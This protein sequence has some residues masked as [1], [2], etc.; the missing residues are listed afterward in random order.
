MSGLERLAHGLGRIVAPNPS[1]MTGPG[2][3][4][5]LL[6]D[7]E[8]AVIDPGPD[9][10]AHLS[11]ILSAAGRARI[12]HIL[13]THAH[14]DHSGLARRLSEATGAPILAFG[15]ARAGRS[16][17]MRRLDLPE[18]GAGIDTVFAPD[19]RLRD[20]DGVHGA[21]W[22][23]GAFWTPGHFGNHL[24]FG[25]RDTVFTGD[26]IMGWSSS[27]ISP[28]DG[29]LRDYL[30]SCARVRRMAPRRLFPGHG[31]TIDAPKARIDDLIRRRAARSEQ[32]R[33]VLG[34]GPADAHEI[35]RRLYADLPL[36]RLAPA[37]RTVF[38]HLLYLRSE[39]VLTTCGSPT[40][41]S[42]FELR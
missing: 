18:D 6:G 28:P 34:A 40:L 26:L 24:C 16:E 33:R 42:R 30:A 19:R 3:N 10:T 22:T 9:M 2:T 23:L 1:P 32:V 29:D 20:G 35:A 15:D 7:D 13:V 5:Y 36:A 12:S 21:G 41:R 31:A 38:A 39:G 8:I 25:W 17:T 37:T 11:A 14:L 27:V 4:T